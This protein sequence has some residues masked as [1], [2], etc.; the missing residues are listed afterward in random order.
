LRDPAVQ[1]PV[2]VECPENNREFIIYDVGQE[3]Q[4]VGRE[5]NRHFFGYWILLKVDIR[6]QLDDPKQTFWHARVFS[7]NQILVK[8]PAWDYDHK[9][10]RDKFTGVQA[11][12]LHSIDNAHDLYKHSSPTRKDARFWR[13]YLLVF[14]PDHELS[15][16]KINAELEEDDDENLPFEM[17]ILDNGK[18]GKTFYMAWHVARKD[19]KGRKKGKVEDDDDEEV[20]KVA[21][22][23]KFLGWS[24]AKEED[25]EDGMM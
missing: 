21:A 7:D 22:Q 12:D 24:K 4:G 10:N 16:K 13:H 5:A 25:D 20:S 3:L 1:V 15:A 18:V 9:K 19:I 11:Y 6:W 2:D 17:I 14:P 8:T 23:L